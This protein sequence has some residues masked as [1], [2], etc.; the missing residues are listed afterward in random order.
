ML[1]LKEIIGR[2]YNIA[3]E[4]VHALFSWNLVVFMLYI[5][6]FIYLPILLLK[7]NIWE[8]L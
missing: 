6:L 7:D 2:L 1:S 4:Y 8:I 3:Y 5:H